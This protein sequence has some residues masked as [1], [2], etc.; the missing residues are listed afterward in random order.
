MGSFAGRKPS[1]LV[2]PEIT[3]HPPTLPRSDRT[4]R[5]DRNIDKVVLGNLC[6]RTWYP[7]YY[8]K[9]LLGDAPAQAKDGRDMSSRD[10]A[11]KA[12]SRR[13][14]DQHP[15][16]LERLYVC[17]SCFKYAK[18]LVAWWG[19]VK[20]CQQ[21]RFVPG[22]KI[23]THPRG[24]RMIYVQQDVNKGTGTGLKKRRGE[25]G[26]RYV[27]EIIQDEGEWSIWEVDGEKDVLFCQNLSLFAKLFL[28]NKSVF[29]DV[30]GFNYF[31]LVYT[32]AP[33]KA[34]P[35]APASAPPPAPIPQITGFFSKE[36]MSWDNNN[37]ACIL[38]F[39]PWQRKGLGALLMGASYEISRREG[40]MGGPEK[41]LSDLGRKSYKQFWSGEIA[42]WLFSLS[43]SA[44]SPRMNMNSNFSSNVN[45]NVIS[46]ASS[47][48]SSNVNG[49]H[50]HGPDESPGGGGGS[51]SSSS[52]SSVLEVV[53]DVED[54]SRA[55]WISPEDCLATLREM[56]LLEDIGLGPGKPERDDPPQGFDG[57]DDMGRAAAAAVAGE[58]DRDRDSNRD[59]S[60][61]KKEAG[62]P[63]PRVRIDMEALRLYVDGNKIKLDRACDPNG[64]VEGY[65]MKKRRQKRAAA[66]EDAEGSSDKHRI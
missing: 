55:T 5:P 52:S 53:V 48:A 15:P 59:R 33:A 28:D 65:A 29:F 44:N 30:T 27:E 4:P 22:R 41:P 34:D 57:E 2:A 49:G 40:I 54:C 14:R 39:P 61:S 9:E 11:P 31:L 20:M 38:I 18:E 45:S 42:R 32:P 56:G 60:A 7:S 46:N 16:M 51:S 21:R 10:P 1:D 6:F 3:Y 63:V 37:L 12:Q 17:P 36:K 66:D 35:A 13:D 64:F 24:A 26:A 50:Q 23:Y 58:A 25:G 62:L 47:I 19:H 43:A 8:G